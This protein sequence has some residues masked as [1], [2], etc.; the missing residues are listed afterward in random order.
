MINKQVT[1]HTTTLYSSRLCVITKSEFKYYKSKESYLRIQKPLRSIPINSIVEV[2]FVKGN[3]KQKTLDHFYI[4][5]E[6]NNN[7]SKISD[8]VDICLDRLDSSRN[9]TETVKKQRKIKLVNQKKDNLNTSSNL[10]SN[11]SENFIEN[12]EN[13]EKIL[14]F[15][16]DKEELV[17]KWVTVLNY[18]I[19]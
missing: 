7:L 16:S 2:D 13:Q 1:W 5:L 19:N 15:S 8:K 6:D 11:I 14:I 10:R 12:Y 4:I 17:K 3:K 9:H 18:F